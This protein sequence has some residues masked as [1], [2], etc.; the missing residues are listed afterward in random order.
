MTGGQYAIPEIAKKLSD[1]LEFENIT[2]YGFARRWYPYK[3]NKSIVI[4]PQL[5][6]GRPTLA[7]YGVSTNNIYDL[8]LGEKENLSTVSRWFDIPASEIKTAIRFEHSLWA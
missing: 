2:G 1:K 5:S 7:E 4:D 8:Y 6:F 3:D